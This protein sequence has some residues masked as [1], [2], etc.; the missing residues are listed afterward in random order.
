MEHCVFSLTMSFLYNIQD[1]EVWANQTKSIG[2][3][4]VEEGNSGL[5]TRLDLC[6]P[7]ILERSTLMISGTH[8][9]TRTQSIVR[10][11]KITMVAHEHGQ[12]HPSLFEPELSV[13][14]REDNPTHK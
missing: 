13:V 12:I 1:A 6:R 7:L 14:Q 3:R 9:G 10:C 2:T 11:Q 8:P 4:K 5:Q